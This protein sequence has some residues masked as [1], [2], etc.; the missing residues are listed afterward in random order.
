MIQPQEF[1][2]DRNLPNLDIGLKGKL[3]LS[4]RDVHHLN[5]EI[6]ARLRLFVTDVQRQNQDTELN[7]K[8][9]PPLDI[10]TP[11]EPRYRVKEQDS[12]SP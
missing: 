6:E 3:R 5:Q 12:V 8:T 7:S 11:Q 1:L 10:S 2:T 4:S 9:T